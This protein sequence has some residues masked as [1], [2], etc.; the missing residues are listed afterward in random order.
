MDGERKRITTFAFY[1]SIQIGFCTLAGGLSIPRK[2]APGAAAAGFAE[3]AIMKK[4]PPAWRYRLGVRTEDSQSSNP[5]S[6]PGSA[7][8]HLLL[9]PAISCTSCSCFPRPKTRRNTWW[10][11]MAAKTGHNLGHNRA[12]LHQR[13]T[14]AGR[15][16][17]RGAETRK[18]YYFAAEAPGGSTPR[19]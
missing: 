5:G 4:L 15:P 2:A 17:D 1:S 18:R 8:R 12:A 13:A 10:G 7:T 14:V 11:T 19:P 9:S 16:H 3:F 6:I